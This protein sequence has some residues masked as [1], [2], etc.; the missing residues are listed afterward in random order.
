MTPPPG[1]V[2]R[3]AHPSSTKLACF[4]LCHVLLPLSLLLLSHL[5]LLPCLPLATRT[6]S[7]PALLPHPRLTI[8][9]SSLQ[10]GSCMTLNSRQSDNSRQHSPPHLPTFPLLPPPLHPIPPLH[11]FLLL[12][13]VLLPQLM[14]PAFFTPSGRPLLPTH[15]PCPL[16][17]PCLPTCPQLHLIP[18][19]AKLTLFSPALLLT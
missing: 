12:S 10:S 8:L 1:W 2:R 6:P 4:S 5:S 11:H 15:L 16:L 14:V 18:H 3:T 19:L 7:E 17:H 13:T 9:S